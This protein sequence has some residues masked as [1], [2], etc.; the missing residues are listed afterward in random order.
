[1]EENFEKDIPLEEETEIEDSK[2]VLKKQ[3]KKLEKEN[4]T[5][6]SILSNILAESAKVVGLNL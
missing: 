4:E 6:K 2:K 1:M 3:I 5:L